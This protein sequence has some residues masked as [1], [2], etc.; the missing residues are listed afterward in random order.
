MN[1]LEEI[2]NMFKKEVVDNNLKKIIFSNPINKININRRIT[3]EQIK[4]KKNIFYQFTYF[5][6]TKVKHKNVDTAELQLNIFDAIKCG[7]KQID[8]ITSTE[9]IK[10][11]TKNN[12]VFKVIKTKVIKEIKAK[13]HNNKKNYFFR[14]GVALDWLVKLD[15]MNSE[16][17]VYK[18]KYKKYKQINNYIEVVK[19]IMY[20]LPNNPNILDFGCGKS[21]LTFALYSYL[22]EEGL[23]PNIIGLDLKKDVIEYCNSLTKDFKMDNIKFI[24]MDIINF[25]LEEHNLKNIDMVISLHACDTAT[26]IAIY[27]AIKWKSKIIL[28][29]PCCHKEV[30]NQIKNEKLKPILKHG[31]LKDRYASIVTDTIR[32]LVL[33]ALGYKTD[34]IEFI[35]IENTPKNIMIRGVKRENVNYNQEA[36][37]N[38]NYLLKE[39][40]IKQKLC[41]LLAEELGYISNIKE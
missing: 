28:S 27:N 25:K 16:G 36:V 11:L 40:N 39:N 10:V 33:D 15:I 1:S 5:Y 23:S 19:N 17:I 24:A 26:D 21:Y 30:N 18:D 22:K 7:Y 32:G 29:V 12:I 34:V 35:D 4:S 6:E 41:C 38:I 2:N 3:I 9:N 13:P 31:I 37:K 20:K 14:E 8:I